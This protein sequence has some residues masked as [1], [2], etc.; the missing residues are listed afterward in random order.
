MR[1]DVREEATVLQSDHGKLEMILRNLI[2]N[3]LKYTRE[4]SVTIVAQPHLDEGRVVFTVAD[5]GPGIA[6]A[7]QAMIFEMFRQSRSPPRQGRGV[8]L[9]LY[10]VTRLT[11]ALGGT[12]NVE[13][14]EGAGAR[15]AISLPIEAPHVT[16]T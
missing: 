15:F 1:W 4:G 10:I 6:A 3:A 8:G 16:T 14:R 12:V 7:D 11:E 2:H 5:T 13:S 9:G